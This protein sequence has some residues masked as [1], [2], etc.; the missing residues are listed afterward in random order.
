MQSYLW[1]IPY[2]VNRFVYFN[3]QRVSS[4]S[5]M[6]NIKRYKKINQCKLML[7]YSFITTSLLFSIIW[8]NSNSTVCNYIIFHVYFLL[9]CYFSFLIKLIII[10]TLKMFLKICLLD[11]VISYLKY[12]FLTSF[13]LLIYG[14]IY[15]CYLHLKM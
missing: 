12:I 6:Y 7:Q 1:L 11:I 2:C 5:I 4:S 3:F 14:A 9:H 15:I 10:V 8:N 13:F